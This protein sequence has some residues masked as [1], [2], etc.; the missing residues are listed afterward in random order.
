M[1][2]FLWLC[3]AYYVNIGIL[4]LNYIYVDITNLKVV[5]PFHLEQEFLISHF[6]V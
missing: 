3:L 5:P 1:S 2:V 6:T 4:Y